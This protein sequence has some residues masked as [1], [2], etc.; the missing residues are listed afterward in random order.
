MGKLCVGL[1]SK[2]SVTFQRLVA[3]HRCSPRIST[4]ADRRRIRGP[5]H[6]FSYSGLSHP[7]HFLRAC[8]LIGQVARGSA[9]EASSPVRVLSP[10]VAG[11]SRGA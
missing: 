3:R 7:S 9:S 1:H 10:G 11:D 8:A 5:L 6:A 4:R 2:Q